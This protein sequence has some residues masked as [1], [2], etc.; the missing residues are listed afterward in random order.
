MGVSLQRL[1][2]ARLYLN[3]QTMPYWRAQVVHRPALRMPVLLYLSL[4]YS[5]TPGP[6]VAAAS[7]NSKSSTCLFIEQ[8]ILKDIYS[9]SSSKT[10]SPRSLRSELAGKGA[11]NHNHAGSHAVS[12]AYHKKSS[13]IGSTD[14]QKSSGPADITLPALTRRSCNSRAYQLLKR[15]SQSC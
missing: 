11:R 5:P 13:W 12:N 10:F 1:P 4:C 2:L 9:L 7:A 3:C 14:R 6:S 15:T 8:S